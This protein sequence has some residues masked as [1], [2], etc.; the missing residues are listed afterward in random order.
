VLGVL[1]RDSFQEGKGT[2]GP[3]LGLRQ[4]L[5]YRRIDLRRTGSSFFELSVRCRDRFGY[6]L[7]D[8]GSGNEMLYQ[9][10]A[11]ACGQEHHTITDTTLGAVRLEPRKGRAFPQP[12]VLVLVVVL[13]S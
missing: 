4:E 9:T 3:S 2:E 1:A 6:F 10:F 7:V 8:S 12:L 11:D 5:G 13:E